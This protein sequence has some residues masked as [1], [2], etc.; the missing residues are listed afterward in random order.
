MADGLAKFGGEQQHGYF[1]V[2]ED[3]PTWVQND[4]EWQRSASVLGFSRQ[5]PS[6][7]SKKKKSYDTK[8]SNGE[9]RNRPKPSTEGQSFNVIH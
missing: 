2:L 8:F 4:L 5:P 3:P 1:F 9:N 6:S 7:V